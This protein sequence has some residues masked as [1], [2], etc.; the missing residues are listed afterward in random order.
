MAAA[1]AGAKVIAIEK[2][3]TIGGTSAMAGGGIAAPES[4]EQKK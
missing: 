4:S 2:L 1:E 3:A